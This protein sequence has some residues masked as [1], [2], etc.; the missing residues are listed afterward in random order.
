MQLRDTELFRQRGLIGEER[1]DAK[2]G[3]TVDVIN[4]ATQS[5][6]GTV[7]DMGVAETRDAIEA[8]SRAFKIWKKKTHGTGGAS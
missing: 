7:P 2:S 4:P 3:K 6:L 5:V 8:A 1:R